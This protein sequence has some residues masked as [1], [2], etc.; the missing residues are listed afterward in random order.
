MNYLVALAYPL[1]VILLY[2]LGPAGFV[3]MA[4]SRLPTPNSTAKHYLG[5]VLISLSL[6]IAAYKITGTVVARF[7]GTGNFYSLPFG[8]QAGSNDAGIFLDLLIW[9][10]LVFV[11]SACVLRPPR[12]AAR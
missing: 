4:K 2:L 12:K 11:I 1:L 3:L 10:A 9:V 7:R 5:T 8:G 6:G